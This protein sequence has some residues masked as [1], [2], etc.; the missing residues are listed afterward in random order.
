MSDAAAAPETG[1]AAAANRME[2]CVNL[3]SR[4]HRCASRGSGTSAPR[5]QDWGA[6]STGLRWLANYGLSLSAAGY[7][8]P[9]PEER[10]SA[11][12]FAPLLGLP[13]KRA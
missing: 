3:L 5:M 6:T 7:A 11:C 10:A 13:G 12:P 2:N 1:A 4:L 9:G 8:V